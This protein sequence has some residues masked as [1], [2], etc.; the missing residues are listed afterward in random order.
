[1]CNQELLI[2]YIYGELSPSER[3]AFEAHVGTCTACREEVETLQETRQ[4]LA[5]WAPPEPALDFTVVRGGRQ[6]AAPPRRLAFVPAWGLAAAASL[7]LLAGAA[8]IANVEMRYGPDGLVV[9]TGWA[10]SGAPAFPPASS[11]DQA[12]DRTGLSQRGA[13]SPA[14]MVANGSS[15]DLRAELV[16]LRARLERLEGAATGSE[17]MQVSDTAALDRRLAVVSANLQKLLADSEKR[18]R[19]EVALQVAEVWKDF[20]AVRASDIARVQQ[21]FGRAQVITNSELRQQRESIESLGTLYRVS[22]QK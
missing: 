7:L 11:S 12:G 14:Q 5:C 15:E 22:Q 18:Q 19:S 20:N 3:A 4:H 16:A 21:T 8:A 13:D 9:R 10:E 6:A 17:T 1:M 2:G